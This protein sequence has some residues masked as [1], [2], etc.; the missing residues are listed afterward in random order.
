MS[1]S[2]TMI[3]H[4][5]NLLLLFFNFPSSQNLKIVTSNKPLKKKIGIKTGN[6]YNETL[7]FA[8]SANNWVRKIRWRMILFKK[9]LNCVTAAALRWQRNASNQYRKLMRLRRSWMVVLNSYRRDM[10]IFLPNTKPSQW[11]F[12]R[13]C[14]KDVLAETECYLQYKESSRLL[15]KIH[16]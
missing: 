1:C 15:Q 11:V 6:S 9:I 3:C 14:W 4:T 13:F 5:D 12:F 16:I 2:I 7:K 8:S 10:S